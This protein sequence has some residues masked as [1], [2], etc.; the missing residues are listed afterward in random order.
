MSKDFSYKDQIEDQIEEL[1][2]VIVSFSVLP[3]CSIFN[4]VFVNRIILLKDDH[5]IIKS[6]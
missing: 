6:K 4:F 2:I 5:F 3:A 1:F